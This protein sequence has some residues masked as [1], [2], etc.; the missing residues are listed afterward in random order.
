[1][2]FG[3]KPTD[4]IPSAPF[5]RASE[6][7]KVRNNAYYVQ[8]LGFLFSLSTTMPKNITSLV[9][10]YLTDNLA[11]Q[12]CKAYFNGRNSNVLPKQPLYSGFFQVYEESSDLVTLF[13]LT[14]N[15]RNGNDISMKTEIV[16]VL[17]KNGEISDHLKN[18]VI[19]F[20]HQNL[21]SYVAR[22]AYRTLLAAILDELH[23]LMVNKAIL[24][25]TD[26]IPGY[27]REAYEAG[28]IQGQ[29]NEEETDEMAIANTQAFNIGKADGQKRR[30]RQ[31]EESTFGVGFD[32]GFWLALNLAKGSPIV[33]SDYKTWLEL[34]AINFTETP[35]YNPTS[36][37][38]SP[39][40]PTS[41]NYS[42]T[43]PSRYL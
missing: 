10:Q 29:K 34:Q 39:T 4:V 21:L 9:L 25:L 40:S 2:D 30:Q 38:Y 5:F 36:P 23:S 16:T 32:A 22:A 17:L 41:P 18:L 35:R 6:E 14:V 19:N 8:D 37:Y 1:M 28:V 11:T 31:L 27:L 13:S 20:K 15:A 3:G 12:G 26:Q 24:Q 7:T 43:S 33:L 42:S